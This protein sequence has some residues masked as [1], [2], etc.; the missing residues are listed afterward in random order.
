LYA[1]LTEHGPPHY[2]SELDTRFHGDV[3]LNET[4]YRMNS[5]HSPSAPT[6]RI[7]A[8]IHRLKAE[9]DAVILA[10]NYQPGEVQDIA[11]FVGDSLNLSIR[12]SQTDARVIVFCGVHFMAETASLL[13][14]GRIVLLPDE[15]AGC[16]MADMVTAEQLREEKGKSPL[17][18]VV[19]YVN[20]SAAV[21]AECDICCTSGNAIKVINSLPEEIPI[22]FVP[23]RHL[24][25]HVA[26]QT[27]REMTLW[28][29][30]CP[31]H[32]FI[33]AG[34]IVALKKDLPGAQVLVHPECSQEVTGLADRV[35]GTGGMLTYAREGA[36][37]T[38]IIG[39]ESGI[40]HRLEKENPGKR[41]IPASE[42]AVCPNMKRISL[43]KILWSLQ[44]L[45]HE[46]HVPEELRA[47][48]KAA[49]DRMIRIR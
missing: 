18:A 2:M 29:G 9:R 3:I 26:A 44:D 13:C 12:A 27:G 5:S 34:D 41:F 20:T 33:R 42:R 17:A 36:A 49:V 8:E 4:T 35:L 25:S 37:D 11:D 32:Q 19:G 1:A 39:T 21:K 31:T 43:E 38:F 48:A 7:T 30:Y 16:P 10:H 23:D 14:P 24:G 6:D 15:Q 46:V 28:P 22:L 47:R 45:R 40:I